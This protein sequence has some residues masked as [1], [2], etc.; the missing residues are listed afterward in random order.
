MTTAII[1]NAAEIAKRMK[2]LDAEKRG[3]GLGLLADLKPIEELPVQE[4]VFVPKPMPPYIPNQ[5]RQ[6]FKSG[7]QCPSCQ[8][9]VLYAYPANRGQRIRLECHYC[10]WNHLNP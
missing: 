8:N 10:N 3:N 1:D 7:D 2:E 6:L 9:G 5:P 4:L